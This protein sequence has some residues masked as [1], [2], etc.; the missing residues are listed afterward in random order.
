MGMLTQQPPLHRLE[1]R[2][3]AFGAPRFAL[4]GC[5]QLPLPPPA[6]PQALIPIQAERCDRNLC[7]GLAFIM[8][9]VH[10]SC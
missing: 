3:T 5:A 9:I 4:W 6:L 1:R 10:K 2:G 7:L 8:Q